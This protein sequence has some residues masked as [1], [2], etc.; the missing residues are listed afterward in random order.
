MERAQCLPHQTCASLGGRAKACGRALGLSCAFVL[1]SFA[2]PVPH[3]AAL[4]PKLNVDGPVAQLK[5]QVVAL[6][7]LGLID[8]PKAEEIKQRINQV[9][10]S[11]Q[12]ESPAKTWEALDHLA[13]QMQAT[14][15]QAKEEAAKDAVKPLT[16]R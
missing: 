15:D 2:V 4:Q 11:A 1:A 8:E 16:P 5:L 6:N 3:A 14:A 12:G 10:G 13:S 7:E 9:E